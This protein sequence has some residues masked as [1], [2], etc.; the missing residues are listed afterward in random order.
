MERAMRDFVLP[1]GFVLAINSIALGQAV[2]SVDLLDPSDGSVFSGVPANIR[3]LDVLVDVADTDV[4][5]ATGMRVLTENGATLA[6]F[7]SDPETPGTQ[8]G[9]VNGGTASR[10]LTSLSQPRGR[11]VNG[12]FTNAGAVAT[13]A[14]DPAGPAPVTT[15]NE[16]N[17]AYSADPPPTDG[18]PAVDG[19]IARIAIDISGVSGPNIHDYALWGAGPTASIP[20]GSMV[21]LRSR[22]LSAR[23]DGP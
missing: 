8:P 1:F 9:L 5:S 15:A 13:G 4:W 18:S 14:F 7:D 16:L 11:N 10:F 20:P 19:Y 6:Y 22:P 23:L 17:V 12:R 3:I 21:V 2:V